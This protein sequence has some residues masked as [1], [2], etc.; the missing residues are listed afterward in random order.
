VVRNIDKAEAYNQLLMVGHNKAR[1][2]MKVQ[3]EWSH[4]DVVSL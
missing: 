4:G 3:F 2:K 1:L